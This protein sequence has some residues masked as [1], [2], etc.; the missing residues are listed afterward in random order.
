[1]RSTIPASLSPLLSV[2]RDNATIDRNGRQ[3]SP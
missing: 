1:M 2:A 3:E